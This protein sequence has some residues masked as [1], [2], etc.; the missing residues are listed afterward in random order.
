MYMTTTILR[1]ISSEAVSMCSSS[2]QWLRCANTGTL[3]ESY[4]MWLHVGD[5]QQHKL[6]IALLLWLLC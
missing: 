1:P 2:T 5:M 4:S 3:A 6:V